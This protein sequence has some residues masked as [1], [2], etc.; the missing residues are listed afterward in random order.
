M[1]AG[2]ITVSVCNSL[3]Y[4]QSFETAVSADLKEA[5][6][7]R[8][9]CVKKRSRLADLVHS[10][11]PDSS[12]PL[13]HWVRFRYRF[14][15][16]SVFCELCALTRHDRRCIC[17][18]CRDRRR[19]PKILLVCVSE[20][21]LT[22]AELHSFFYAAPTLLSRLSVP[23]RRAASHRLRLCQV[24]APLPGRY[25]HSQQRVMCHLCDTFTFTRC[26][27]LPPRYGL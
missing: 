26:V 23:R 21:T 9:L 17:L 25:T 3:L 24:P 7:I 27:S 11:P 2:A 8:N 18:K 22:V 5:E 10:Y 15:H 13:R 19:T 16:A 20:S 6:A 1:V 14:V 4:S 12:V